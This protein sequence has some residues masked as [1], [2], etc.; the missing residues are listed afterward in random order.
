MHIENFMKIRRSY[1]TLGNSSAEM[2]ACRW[3]SDHAI[4]PILTNLFFVLGD[5]D[6]PV[7]DLRSITTGLEKQ[8][9]SRRTKKG[10]LYYIIY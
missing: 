1:E 3:V 6:Y 2:R 5:L 4:K 8:L 10:R 7:P 9:T